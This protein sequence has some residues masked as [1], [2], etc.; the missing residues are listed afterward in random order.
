MKKNLQYLISL[1][2]I[3]LFYA[4]NVV[5]AMEIQY[6]EIFG[7]KLTSQ[8]TTQGLVIYVYSFAVALG[9]VI[10][11]CILVSAGL[12]FIM[13]GGEPA[14]ISSA[15]N[16]IMGSFIGLIVLFSSYLLMNTINPDLPHPADMEM[17]CDRV[18][19]DPLMKDV[20][21]C[22]DRIKVVD[23]GEKISSEMTLDSSA[24]LKLED[25]EKIVIKRYYNL[26]EIWTFPK[27]EYQDVATLAYRHVAT[28]DFAD[29]IMNIEITSEVKSF[30][31]VPYQEGVYLYDDV[32]LNVVAGKI[33][34]FFTNQSID[35]LNDQA[36]LKK[37]KSFEI[38]KPRFLKE[39]I[40]PMPIFF[41]ETGYRGQCFVMYS[42]DMQLDLKKLKFGSDPEPFGYNI[43]SVIVVSSKEGRDEIGSVTFYS[44]KN[45]IIEKDDPVDETTTAT[46]TTTTTDTTIVAP[47]PLPKFCVRPLTTTLENEIIGQFC[48]TGF[49]IRS[50][51]IDGPGGV[52]LVNGKGYCQ[53]WSYM[54]MN[55]GNCISNI[56][57]SDINNPDLMG[58]KPEQYMIF[59]VNNKQ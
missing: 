56:E 54:D 1:L 42:G 32:N 3:A 36:F 57:T 18:L 45:C 25:N 46:T 53:Y 22:I 17:N 38:V 16:K 41:A 49:N 55:T 33:S 52:V 19:R 7:H 39:K 2:V 9:A 15:K 27:T 31:L 11:F 21:V 58:Y 10:V 23:G 47:P 59:P 5:L 13:A 48:G 44:S 20:P 8:T 50:I 24:N 4:S 14:K 51:R 37:T 12:D 6:P 40:K 43:S 35:D 26:K 29:E 34:P 28:T 30:K